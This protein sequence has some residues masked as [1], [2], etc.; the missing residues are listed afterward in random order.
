[1]GSFQFRRAILF[2]KE[3]RQPFQCDRSSILQLGWMHFILGGDLCQRLLFLQEFL[4]YSCFE[5]G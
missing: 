3:R 1:M 5:S 2:L 4:N